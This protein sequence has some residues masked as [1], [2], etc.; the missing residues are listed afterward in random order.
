MRPWFLIGLVCTTALGLGTGLLVAC[1]VQTNGTEETPD[2]SIEDGALDA[3]QS[4][5]LDAEPDA[6]VDVDGDAGL[7]GD[8]GDHDAGRPDASCTGVRCGGQCLDARDCRSCVGSPLL[9]GSGACVANCADCTD[10]QGVATPIECFA[11]DS[12]HA[13]PIGTCQYDDA[14]SYCLSGNYL[15]Q[16]QSGQ[17]YQCACSNVSECPGATQACVPLGNYDAGFCLTCGESTIGSMQGRPC[18]D[19]GTCQVSQALCQ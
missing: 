9:C 12:N 17:G 18:K 13:N 7:D 15:G 5:A 8:A 16:Y 6:G 11:C 14:S 2:S 19:G 10:P 1:S 4:A 3:R